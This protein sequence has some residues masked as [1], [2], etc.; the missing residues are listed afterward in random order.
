M[1]WFFPLKSVIDAGIPVAGGSDHMIGHDKNGALNP[2]NP[3]FN[4][5]MCITRRMRNGETFYPQERITRGQA[6]RMYTAGPAWLQFSEKTRGSLEAGKL[7]DAVV[8]DR[9][10]LTCPED[11][12]RAIEPLM[13][14]VGGSIVYDRR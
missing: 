5:W 7:A 8:I 9:N 3:F 11:E 1:R 2:Y 6:L 14:I 4:M 13:T 12:I 10:F